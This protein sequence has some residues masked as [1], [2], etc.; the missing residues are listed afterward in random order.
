MAR[1]P[2][3]TRAD[4]AAQV[5]FEPGGAGTGLDGE[6]LSLPSGAEVAEQVRH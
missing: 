1:P 2:K 4:S 5:C 6:T 3:L